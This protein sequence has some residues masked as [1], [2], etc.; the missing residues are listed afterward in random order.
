MQ[1][2]PTL[3]WRTVFLFFGLLLSTSALGS[4]KEPFYMGISGG[5]GINDFAPDFE[6]FNISDARHGVL[7]G[8]LFAGYHINPYF[9]IETGLTDF[10]NYH[11][12]GSSD[13][14]L[15]FSADLKKCV[16]NQPPYNELINEN[17]SVKNSIQIYALDITAK[18]NW[19]L[20]EHFM[21]FIKT[22]GAY[23]NASIHSAVNITID[24]IPLVEQNTSANNSGSFWSHWDPL[25][26]VGYEYML[27]N[28]IST[29]FE[30]DYYFPVSVHGN[31]ISNSG[32]LKPS[33]ILGSLVYHFN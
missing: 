25:L 17:I 6:L 11:N 14:Y 31:T 10:G 28:A 12:Q 9:D 5:V 13:A 1:K 16:P 20:T 4:F 7:G 21:L 3:Q 2:K 15:C 24:G 8:R 30:Y 26:G 19:P 22:G 33:I 32:D 18:W 27:S 29:R 23:V